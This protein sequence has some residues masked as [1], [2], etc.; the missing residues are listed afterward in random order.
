MSS[1]I[2]AESH[3]PAR[4]SPF[5]PAGIL[6][7]AGIKHCIVG[8]A[9]VRLYGSDLVIADLDLAISD[10]QVGLALSV[11]HDEGFRDVDFGPGHLVF[12]PVLGKPGG[13]VA[14]RLQFP[15]S[16]DYVVLSLAS[17]WHQE[18]NPDTTFLPCPDYRFPR[19]LAY[20][21]ALICTIDALVSVGDNPSLP[22]YQYAIMMVLLEKRPELK[23]MVSP[24]DQFFIDF[25]MKQRARSGKLRVLELRKGI[26]AGTISVDAARAVVPRPD[27]S[28]RRIKEKYLRQGTRGGNGEGSTPVA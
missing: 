24:G 18:I 11:L 5:V 15:S 17:C 1:P 22:R 2:S 19:F 6:E 9:V 16:P 10:E 23:G 28:R 14:C 25:F 26:M 21:E 7:R 20:L 27:S 8:N 4:I 13:W 12:L 3:P